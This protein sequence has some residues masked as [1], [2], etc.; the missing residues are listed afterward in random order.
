M[1]MMSL[2]M[3]YRL[4]ISQQNQKEIGLL[5]IV[6]ITKI[7]VNEIPLRPVLLIENTVLITLMRHVLP[8]ANTVLIILKKSGKGEILLRHVHTVANT[9]LIILKKSGKG[10]ILLRHVHPQKNTVL[11]TLSFTALRL[12]ENPGVESTHD[13]NQFVNNGTLTARA[14][15]AANFGLNRLKPVYARNAARTVYYGGTKRRLNWLLSHFL[16]N[17]RK[18]S[19]PLIL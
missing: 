1:V 11:I 13:S 6:N 2:K 9:V 16:M 8:I 19:F 15:F 7:N 3:D 14:D 10:V 12:A 4:L 5:P 18:V 17:W